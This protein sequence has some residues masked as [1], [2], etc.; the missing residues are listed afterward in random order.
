MT[1]A[2]SKS[3]NRSKLIAI[4]GNPN[5]GK[6]TIF[7]CITGLNQHVGNYPGVTV[8]KVVGQFSYPKNS[9]LKHSVIDI[10]GTYSLSAFTPDEYIA[11]SAIFGELKD[12]GQPDVLI[13]L[14]DATNLERSIY[15]LL[16]IMQSNLPLVVG[17][18]MIDLAQRRGINIDTEKLSIALG[19]IDVIPLIG[20]KGKGIEQLKEKAVALIEQNH[21]EPLKYFDPDTEKLIE[22]L[23][24]QY[25]NHT[26]SRAHYMR[27]IFD[28][29]GPAE[30]SFLVVEGENARKMLDEGRSNIK[31]RFG[32]LLVAET[33]TL[34]RK[35]QEIYQASASKKEKKTQAKSERIDNFILHPVLGPI[36]LA[37][38][39]VFV[40]QSIFSWAEPFMELIDSIFSIIAG[41]IETNMADG[42]LRSLI[43]DGIIGGV[44]SVLIFIPQITFLFIFIALMEDSGYMPRAAFLVDRM[45]RW[46]GLSG[47]SFI[48]MLSAFACA[49]PG[50]MATRTI[51]DRKQRIMT[52]MVAPLMTCSARLPV[53]A[54]MIAAFI[55]YQSYF[56]IL[57]LQGLVLTSLYL[58]GL[59]VAVAVSFILKKTVYKTEQ[60][61]FMM[62]MPSYKVPTLKSV[63]IRIVN[64]V[65]AFV[66]RAGTVIMAITIIIWAL[67]Y[68]PRS[69]NLQQD[70]QD[71]IS[72]LT[73]NYDTQMIEF[74]NQ[75]ETIKSNPNIFNDNIYQELQSNLA[76]I[77][78]DQELTSIQENLENNYP[79]NS[80][81]LYLMIYQKQAELNYQTSELV[82]SNQLA[83]TQIRN[84]YLGIMGQTVEPLF[85]PLG[86]DWKI[87]MSVLASFPAREVIIAVLGTIYNLGSEVDEESSSLI[88]KMRL[89]TWE[90]GDKIGQPVFT[91]AVALS[92]MI[93]FALCCQCGATVVTIK[94]ET[95][96]WF[97]AIATFTYMTTLAYISSFVLYQ[98][99]NSMGF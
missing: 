96:S 95:N 97:Y 53:Y 65:K 72:Q 11:A 69:E 80:Q 75:L 27:I 81:L 30:K 13:A 98:L 82:L 17:L 35:A 84:S 18:N 51:E 6:T 48:P 94:H 58:L 78:S 73:S 47:K 54:I 90:S 41:I 42:P 8:E 36:I 7:N 66:V 43:T 28:E 44:G 12:E 25:G 74:E 15:L 26:R 87:T 37:S 49:V 4:C 64:R 88:S 20:N 76:S 92:I 83:G 79:D 14:L 55:P 71:S 63:F 52:I 31:N 86:W 40:F 23:T 9:S 50:I 1:P 61:T 38:L 46:C 22:L 91:T 5:C 56:G 77:N 60:G 34:T 10:P 85:K 21:R 29:N 59:L 62:E 70:Y 99:L 33:Q 93:F 2:L 32:S 89:A 3:P 67:S 68:Y 39:M 24:D 19:G 57:N 45:F 16:Q